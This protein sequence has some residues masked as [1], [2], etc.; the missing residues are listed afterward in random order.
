M[1]GESS[2][3]AHDVTLTTQLQV[4]LQ[5][6]T[7]ANTEAMNEEQLRD[8]IKDINTGLTALAQLPTTSRLNDLLK[9]SQSVK[10]TEAQISELLQEGKKVV[11]ERNNLKQELVLTQKKVT[12]LEARV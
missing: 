5:N 2:R 10:S 4:E 8:H 9:E 11:T 6:V 3:G 7:Q 1:S 12:T